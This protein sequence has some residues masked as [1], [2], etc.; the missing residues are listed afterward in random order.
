MNCGSAAPAAAADDTED[1][2]DNENVY[3]NDK[4]DD[5]EYDA[6]ERMNMRKDND[7]GA[8]EDTLVWVRL[9]CDYRPRHQNLCSTTGYFD[10][11]L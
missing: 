3:E 1:D 10:D 11:A 8:T 7:N 6:K 5:N 4:D 9:E 2:D